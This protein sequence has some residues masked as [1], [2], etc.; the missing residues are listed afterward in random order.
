MPRNRAPR[1][2]S[3]EPPLRRILMSSLAMLSAEITAIRS[4]PTTLPVS[5]TSRILASRY[6][7]ES[8]RSERSSAGQATW[9]S[10]SRTRT[11]TRVM[12]SSL[13]CHAHGLEPAGHGFDAGAHLLGL[14][15]Q[16]GAL[17]N[18]VVLPVTK[19]AVLFL[20]LLDG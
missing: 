14:L 17:G 12:R 9:Y 7:A 13:T 16:V 4:S 18:E 2:P 5:R 19:G 1:S 20:E 15:Q 6:S 3:S 11:L 8:S 10:L